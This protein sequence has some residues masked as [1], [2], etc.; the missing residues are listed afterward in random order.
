M[1]GIW[2]RKIAMTAALMI[3]V[4]LARFAVGC[5]Y[6]EE[7]ARIRDLD[8]TVVGNQ[9]VPQELQGI[10]EEKKAAPFKLTYSDGQG[11]YIAEGYGEQE[12]GG[13]SI[14]VRDLYLTEEGIVFSAEL[15]GP[16]KGEDAGTEN[17]FPYIVVKTEFLEDPVIF[18]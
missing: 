7:P 1:R 9:E 12:S 11:L 13:Y 2:N 4:F 15:M 3:W 6:G 14:A 16:E 5:A 8:F 10:I 17:S 18:R